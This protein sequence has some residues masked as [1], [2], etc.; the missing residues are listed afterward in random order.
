MIFPSVNEVILN[1]MGKIPCT[2]SQQN[3]MKHER[4][5]LVC[6]A[7][8]KMLFRWQYI[9]TGYTECVILTT[10]V[11]SGKTIFRQY[12]NFV[13]VT[14][15]KCHVTCRCCLVNHESTNHDLAFLTDNSYSQYSRSNPCHVMSSSLVY[16]PCRPYYWTNIHGVIQCWESLR[17]AVRFRV[18]RP[19]R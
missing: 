5:I 10:S 19:K 15:C 1:G 18:T 12:G 2:Q 14:Q 7:K 4:A 3:A 9:V 17:Q 6:T 13:S 16:C 11:Q 8:T